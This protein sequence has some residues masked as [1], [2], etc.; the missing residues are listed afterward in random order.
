MK[1]QQCLDCGYIVILLGGV[2]TFDFC[3][4]CD[5]TNWVIKNE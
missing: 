5:S 3:P 2:K 1:K 4:N